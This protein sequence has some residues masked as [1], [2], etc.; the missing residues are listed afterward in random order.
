MQAGTKGNFTHSSGIFSRFASLHDVPCLLPPS[1]GFAWV[2]T[3]SHQLV[4]RRLVSSR[5]KPVKRE[6][7]SRT[8]DLPDTAAE[9]H[10]SLL[11]HQHT[12]LAAHLVTTTTVFQVQA[13]HVDVWHYGTS[14]SASAYSKSSCA[15]I[16][17]EKGHDVTKKRRLVAQSRMRSLCWSPVAI[18]EDR[19]I[20]EHG[21]VDLPAFQPSHVEVSDVSSDRTVLYL[22][23]VVNSDDV[24]DTR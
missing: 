4:T 6:F 8:E 18:G 12:V 2:S 20:L 19:P 9:T 10:S 1:A 5:C 7:T 14:S 3:C 21:F 16:W 22:R 24:E 15:S 11:L 13:D 17:S 23:H